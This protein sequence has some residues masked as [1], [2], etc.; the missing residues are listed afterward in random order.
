MKLFIKG[1]AAFAF[2]IALG[3]FA[4]YQSALAQTS[5]PQSPTLDNAVRNAAL[6]QGLHGFPRRTHPQWTAQQQALV[7]LRAQLGQFLYSDHFLS[8]L[9]ETSCSTCHNANFHFADG[10]RI[11]SGLYCNFPNHDDHSQIFCQPPPS[12]E[13]GN[14]IGPFRTA[15][16]NDLR[17]APSTFNV[18]LFPSEMLNGRFF[19]NDPQFVDNHLTDINQLQADFGFFIQPPENTVYTRSLLGGQAM[20]PTP[21]PLEM[22]GDF[23]NIGQ[24]FLTPALTQ[25]EAVF[26]GL[27]EKV[28]NNANY[29]HLFEQAYP[30]N[31]S[32]YPAYDAHIGPNDA[33][34]FSAITDAIAYFQEVDLQMTSAPWDYFLTG[35]NN[36]ISHRAKLGALTFFTRGKCAMCHSGDLFSDFR[37]YNIG[38]PQIGE[39]EDDRDDSDPAYQ[40]LH[41]WD[42]GLEE[43]TQNRADRFKLRTVPLRG[44]TLTPPYM[45]DGAF[46]SLADAIRAHENP[47][48]Y[49]EAYDVTAIAEQDVADQDGKKPIGPV[50]DSRNPVVVGP[51][52]EYYAHL[53]NQDVADLIAFLRTL[54]DPRMEHTA[55]LAPQVLPSRLRPDVP[56][57]ARYATFQHGHID[58]RHGP[59]ERSL[60]DDR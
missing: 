49:Y 24:P 53:S 31:E 42:F 47:R 10:R 41:T 32:V 44:V 33:I 25:H 30:P 4:S 45:H 48:Q 7:T 57:P 18:G 21:S 51:G 34:P 29:H 3:V 26:Q 50:F 56:G 52:S 20:K 16:S 59:A 19:F 36:A 40:G 55:A 14:V 17:N 58:I 9:N 37:S 23:P 35:K 6:S 12:P 1:L 15:G 13:N 54:T 27:A 5:D 60:D 38:V 46:A 39:G 2:A 8:G 22:S 43:I 28:S 11:S